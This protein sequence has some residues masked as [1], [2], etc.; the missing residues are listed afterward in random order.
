MEGSF[1]VVLRHSVKRGSSLDGADMEGVRGALAELPV[2]HGLR[3][4]ADALL[5]AVHGVLELDGG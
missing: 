5:L 4:E 2:P 1:E 3:S